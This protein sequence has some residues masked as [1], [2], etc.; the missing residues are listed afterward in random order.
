MTSK[1]SRLAS[2]GSL[3]SDMQ[4]IKDKG[5]ETSGMGMNSRDHVK[6]HNAHQTEMP[7]PTRRIKEQ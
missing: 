5:N 6:H 4:Q 7:T 1:T 2:F 3:D